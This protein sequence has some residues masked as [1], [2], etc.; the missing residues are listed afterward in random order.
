M[1][2]AFWRAGLRALGSIL[3]LFLRHVQVLLQ[4]VA[5]P[6]ITG[7]SATR[8]RKPKPD[9][10]PFMVADRIIRRSGFNPNIFSFSLFHCRISLDGWTKGSQ[11]KQQTYSFT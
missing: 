10:A 11:L 8:I 6:G 3:P 9:E 4:E 2:L 1:L 7:C 5:L